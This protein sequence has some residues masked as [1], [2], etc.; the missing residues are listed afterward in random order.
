MHAFKCL[1]YRYHGSDHRPWQYGDS[2]TD[3]IR[4][5]LNT[6]YKLSP[7]LVA[8]GQHAAATG[9]PFVTRGDLMVRLSRV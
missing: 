5:Y 1:N 8:A 9:F 3:T 7:S 4:S 6:R 2:V